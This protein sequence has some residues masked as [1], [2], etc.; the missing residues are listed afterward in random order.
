MSK[1]KP[2]YVLAVLITAMLSIT[3]TAFVDQKRW[4]A[5][6][7]QQ[8]EE[9]QRQAV[10]AESQLRAMGINPPYGRQTLK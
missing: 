10:Q 9:A 7:K 8:Q 1:K 2:P 6:E 3:L 5:R 4:E